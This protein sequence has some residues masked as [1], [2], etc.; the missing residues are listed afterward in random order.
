MTFLSRPSTPVSVMGD[1][2]QLGSAPPDCGDQHLR[3]CGPGRL[4][5]DRE[6]RLLMVTDPPNGVEYRRRPGAIRQAL[7]PKDQRTDKVLMDGPALTGVSLGRVPGRRGFTSGTERCTQR[8]WPE[9]LV[10]SFGFTTSVSRLSGPGSI[11]SSGRGAL[12]FG[13][14]EPCWYAFEKTGKATGRRPQTDHACV[15]ISGR[16]HERCQ[17]CNGNRNQ[18]NACAVRS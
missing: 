10:A 7:L 18:S 3:R 2:W 17:Q 14:H 15:H 6:S 5:G 9:S 12:P 16:T 1:L 4:L 8:L 11:G 13:K